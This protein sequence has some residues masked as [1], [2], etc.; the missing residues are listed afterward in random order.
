[1]GIAPR[2]ES[3]TVNRGSEPILAPTIH[4]S[5]FRKLGSPERSPAVVLTIA[6]SDCSAG[7][8]LQADLKA[9]G[10][11][12]VFG[13][14]ATTCVVAEVPGKVSRIDRVDSCNV[15]QQIELLL[16]HFPVAAIK[17]GLLYSAEIVETVAA[18]LERS[19]KGI[20]LVVDP[21]MIATSGDALLQPAAVESY[22]ASL[23]PRATLVTPNIPEAAA[24]TGKPVRNLEEMRIAGEDLAQR[25]GTRFL[26]KGGH[27]AGESA[28]DLLFGGSAVAEFS[29]PFVEGVSTHGTGCTYSAA[30][31]AGL[32]LGNDL[33]PAI[34]RAKEFVSRAI[35]EHFSW[36]VSSGK[37]HALN[38]QR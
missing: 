38:L 20:P 26:I 24:L 10:A 31:A 15:G 29:A 37:I 12:G 11:F 8:G 23:F 7:A 35:R 25:F 30:I 36:E 5:Q 22:R 4:D 9:F 2:R 33:E 16:A 19:A 21:V 27:L 32:A 17:T 28:T 18:I 13:L 6:G 34:L 1:M 14:T 3:S